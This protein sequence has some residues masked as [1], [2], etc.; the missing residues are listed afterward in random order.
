MY[1]LQ[2]A[3]ELALRTEDRIPSDLRFIIDNGCQ[4]FH[5]YLGE[6]IIEK[7]TR[8]TPEYFYEVL[9]D[10]EEKDKNI[11]KDF[12]RGNKCVEKIVEYIDQKIEIGDSDIQLDSI[13]QMNTDTQSNEDAGLL[14]I[15]KMR[16]FGK[17]VPG[18]MLTIGKDIVTGGFCPVDGI[19][20]EINNGREK[21]IQSINPVR[22]VSA[23]CTS[24][25][26][27]AYVAQTQIAKYGFSSIKNVFNY[28]KNT[29][30]IDSLDLEKAEFVI[31]VENEDAQNQEEDNSRKRSRTNDNDVR[32]VRKK[33]RTE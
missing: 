26:V 28:F 32:E 31:N 11:N 21:G 9:R 29:P 19:W 6:E 3:E 20:N 10:L 4:N 5:Y 25:V 12:V 33:R 16:E 30:E 24:L 7:N 22:L 8:I 17:A 18:R 2:F 27:P 15:E 1:S 23:V 14:S 13:P